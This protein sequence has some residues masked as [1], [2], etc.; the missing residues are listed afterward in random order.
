MFKKLNYIAIFNST[1]RTLK[2]QLTFKPGITVIRGENEAGKSFVLEMIRYALYGTK[3]LRGDRSDYSKLEVTLVME[4]AGKDYKIIRKGTKAT[5]NINEAV[6]T[7]AT[8]DFITNLLGFDLSVFDIC[9]NAKQGE[10]DALTNDMKPTQRREMVDQVIGLTQ[11][12]EVEKD[13]R[14][15]ANQFRRLAEALSAQIVE[16]EVPVKPQDYEPSEALRDRLE[17]EIKI[18]AQRE[19]LVH[20]DAPEAPTEPETGIEVLAGHRRYEIDQQV[21]GA[22]ENRLSKLPVVE[23]SFTKEELKRARQSVEQRER[24]PA[25]RGIKESQLE[26][27]SHDWLLISSADEVIECD[28]CGH[29]VSGEAPPQ[30][31][32]LSPLEIKNERQAQLRWAGHNYDPDLLPYPNTNLEQIDQAERALEADAERQLLEKQ[33]ADL[34]PQPASYAS[35]VA[36]HT[37]YARE[38]IRYEEKLMAYEAYLAQKAE[39]DA[40]PEPEPMLRERLDM[41]LRY[42]TLLTKYDAAKDAQD[43]I[44]EQ[45]DEANENRE[46][47]KRGSEALKEVRKEVKQYIIPALSKVSSQLLEEMTRGERR[48]I[49][50]TDDFEIFVDKQHVRT[51]SG[52]GVSV[53]NLALRIALG[54]VLTQSVI[55]V[56]LADEIDA[57][58]AEKRTKA[59]HESLRRLRSRL[60][61]IIVVTHKDFEGDETLWL[62]S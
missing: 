21:R 57:N 20:I 2:N 31:P 24:G 27:W 16:L 34:G 3:A 1:G 54:Q 41:A 35:E 61:Q 50:I 32:E 46:G 12:E 6:G 55:P 43:R 5:V 36:D 45:V 60:T 48:K 4:I 37:R 56:F 47:Y 51:L 59:T 14:A 33:L 62:T 10:L 22:I 44:Q 13:C 11:F 25:P 8:N 29:I 58:M 28:N 53:V 40:L 7:V 30:E 9:A 15:E 52:S 23:H 49:F 19:A 42:E 18:A 39:V 26:Q 38:L 17:T